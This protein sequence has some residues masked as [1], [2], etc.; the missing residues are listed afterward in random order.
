ME[1]LW[2]ILGLL[3]GFYARTLHNMLSDIYKDFYE[4]RE[5]SKAGV[6]KPIVSRGNA[7][8]IPID[9]SKPTGVIHRITP[10]QVEVRR[11]QKRDDRIRSGR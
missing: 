2:A 5:A 3:V 10:E 8:N 9:L 11:Q 6:V 7:R 4:R 1:A